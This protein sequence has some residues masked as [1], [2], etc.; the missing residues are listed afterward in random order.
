MIRVSDLVADASLEIEVLSGRAGLDKAVTWTHVA[1][2][3]DAAQWLEGGELLLTTGLGVPATPDDQVSY[4]RSLARVKASCLGIG[5]RAPPL[6]DELF[7]ASDALRLP[8]VR[9]GVEVPFS[10]ITRVVAA[11]NLDLSQTRLAIQI[12]ILETLRPWAEGAA[13]SR[14]VFQR[15]ESVTGF[16]IYVVDEAGTSVLPDMKDAPSTICAEIPELRSYP[17]ITDG[18]GAV[19]PIKGPADTFVVL[20]HRSDHGATGVVVARQVATV[21]AIHLADLYRRHE[22]NL[23]RGGEILNGLLSD[24]DLRNARPHLLAH[25]FDLDAP[26]RM[27]AVRPRTASPPD[28]RQ[29]YTRLLR[30]GI[31]GIILAAADH[32]TLLSPDL[33]AQLAAVTDSLELVGG[34]SDTFHLGAPLTRYQRQAVWTMQT[35]AGDGRGLVPYQRARNFTPWL[36]MGPESIAA[37]VAEI[38][39]PIRGYDEQRGTDLLHTLAVYL[40]TQ[41]SVAGSAAELG[42]HPHT[43]RYRLAKI[44]DLTG[45]R[46]V[47]TQHL[48]ELWWAV[49]ADAL[50]T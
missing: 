2:I 10:R 7:A 17:I 13:D 27:V 41:R 31:P 14:T 44:E 22:E 20:Q 46:L 1:E 50:P 23:R 5:H 29:L 43:L 25:G 48:A 19:V 34:V 39:G 4:L 35:T 28:P 11:G 3:P 42:V 16:D 37:A 47:D 9:V 32:L 21:A 30:S 33:P 18:Y 8:V 45:R 40:R 38:L 15:L 26:H 6:S 24:G 49:Q 36:A 12:R